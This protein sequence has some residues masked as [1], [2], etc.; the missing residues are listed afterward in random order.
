MK[1]S[2]ELHAKLKKLHR[3]MIDQNGAELHNP[4]PVSIPI[5]QQRPPTLKEQIQRV[6]RT[7]LS[8]QAAS[9]GHETYEEANDF[10]IDDDDT[11]YSPYELQP[12]QDDLEP[13]VDKPEPAKKEPAP[14]PEPEKI[15]PVT[16][17]E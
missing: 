12:M 3:A 1:I 15:D 9:Q 4:T 6:L 11:M 8:N 16:K 13:I 7:E 17:D 14:E 2:N 5:G 10:D